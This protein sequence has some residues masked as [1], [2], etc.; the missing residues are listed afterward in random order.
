MDSEVQ[1]KRLGNEGILKIAYPNKDCVVWT[2][3]CKEGIGGILTQEGHVIC[4]ESRKLKEHEKELC[5]T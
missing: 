4:Y 2:D 3:A 5:C 1:G